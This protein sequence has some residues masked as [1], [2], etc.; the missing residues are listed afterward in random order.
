MDHIE[1]IIEKI[2]KDKYSLLEQQ[3]LKEEVE[4]YKE[5]HSSRLHI[6]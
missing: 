3:D 4:E 6:M 1:D 2:S 5:V